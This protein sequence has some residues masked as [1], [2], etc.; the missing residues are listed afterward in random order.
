MTSD[1]QIKHARC[2]IQL[3]TDYSKISRRLTSVSLASKTVQRVMKNNMTACK[4]KWLFKTF[5]FS[6]Y[7]CW[8][9]DSSWWIY[10]LNQPKKV[11]PGVSVSLIFMNRKHVPIQKCEQKEKKTHWQG[12]QTS[13]QRVWSVKTE[14]QAGCQLVD[15]ADT[16]TEKSKPLTQ[17]ADHHSD[18]TTDTTQRW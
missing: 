6:C 14:R 13:R 1:K 4:L 10:D 2:V 11:F 12:G 5:W 9:T 17:H 7:C 15:N 8:L 16:V 18:N 3:K